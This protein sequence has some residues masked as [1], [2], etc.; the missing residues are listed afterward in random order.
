MK[1][2][3]RIEDLLFTLACVIVLLLTGCTK[4]S[5]SGTLTATGKVF[6]VGGEA[7]NLLY[8]N[9]MVHMDIVRENAES[10]VETNDSDGLG[11]PADIKT[12][13]TIRYKAG[14]IISGY[15]VDLA[16]VSPEAAVEYVKAMP[17]LNK[18]TI[19]PVKTEPAKESSS[20]VKPILQKIKDAIGGDDQA[21]VIVG[22]GTYTALAKDRSIKYQSSLCTELLAYA[23]DE[24]V[25]PGSGEGLK[26]TLI[27]FAGRLGQL[28]AKKKD[29][30]KMRISKATIQGGRLT[31]LIYLL[32]REDGTDEEVECPSCYE[33]ED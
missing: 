23:D 20:I 11:D 2:E 16:K 1:E 17:E 12:V 6:K 10:V 13:R 26:S 19:E 33:V 14:P 32:E 31:Y 24:V 3:N 25:M 21:K 4:I 22:D 8:V 7:Y 18:S 29:V 27:H 15:A 28:V 9:G 30:T 5:H